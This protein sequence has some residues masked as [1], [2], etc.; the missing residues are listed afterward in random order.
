MASDSISWGGVALRVVAAAVLVFATYNPEG[1]SFYHWALAPLAQDVRS[2]GAPKFLAATVLVAGWVIFLQATRRSIGWTGALLVTAIS[3][4]VIW[5]LIDR[6][7]VTASSSRGMAHVV[8]IAVSIVLGVGMSWSHF[9]RR[10]SG[11]AD[12]DVV[13]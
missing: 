5:L 2:F 9:S 12:T 13:D 10:L 1:Q 4:G 3:G 11:Q 7:V 8:L 6:N